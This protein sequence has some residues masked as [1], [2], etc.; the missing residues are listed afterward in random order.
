MFFKYLRLTQ[1]SHVE[2]LITVKLSLELIMSKFLSQ[3]SQINFL[4]DQTDRLR[5]QIHFLETQIARQ[6][7]EIE[8]QR[9]QINFLEDQ[10]DRL[11]AQIQCLETQ[12]ARQKSDD[13]EIDDSE[14]FRI[15]R[16]QRPHRL[17]QA[18]LYGDEETEEGDEETED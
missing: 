3:R 6:K 1:N 8:R 18:H 15:F 13:E 2:G 5:A 9:S 4:A 17:I 11:R 10:T 7:F 12:I 16:L 14:A